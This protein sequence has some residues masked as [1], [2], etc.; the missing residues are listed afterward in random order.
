MATPVTVLA[1]VGRSARHGIV[2]KG[3]RYL[4]ALA[5]VD[6]VVMDNTGT[7]TVGRP[8]VTEVIALGDFPEAAV[9]RLAAAVERRSEHPLA[10]G[11]VRAAEARGLPIESAKEFRVYPGE[12]VSATLDGTRVLVGTEALMQRFGVLVRPPVVQRVEEL[13]RAGQS[14]VLV[15]RGDE[16]AGIVALADTVR[17]AAPEAIDELRRLGVRRL[18]LL[19]GDRREV[20]A[21]VAARLRVEFQGEM[22]PGDKIAAIEGLQRGGHVVAMIGDGIN[23][24]PA[25]PQ[26]DVG[27]AMGVAGADAAIE[28]AHV[29]LMQDDWRAVPA[30][31]AIGRRAFATI[32]QNLWFT[33]AYNVVGISLAAVGWRP[34]IAAAAAQSL[35]DVV[36]MLNASRLLRSSPRALAQCTSVAPRSSA[37]SS[38]RD[39][40]E[41]CVSRPRRPGRIDHRAGC[42]TWR[43]I[44]PLHRSPASLV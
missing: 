1:A 29:A 10:S 43:L 26:A 42:S 33:A 5:K 32:K 6:V 9:L 39:A 30:T 7:M 40:R 2:I 18:L 44:V 23:D 37:S 13:T 21:A 19:S 20:A 8:D 24:A 27:I 25:L 17:P 11:I 22:L 36:V 15:T 3:G 34:P 12:G 16:I 4:E 38:G 35:P 31:V 41:P 14:A 28:A